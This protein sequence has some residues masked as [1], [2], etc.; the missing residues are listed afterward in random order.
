MRRSP[1][2]A[3]RRRGAQGRGGAWAVPPAGGRPPPPETRRLPRDPQV[4]GDERRQ[5]EGATEDRRREVLQVQ[6]RRA[7]RDILLGGARRGAPGRPPPG[8]P[9]YAPGGRGPGPGAGD[10]RGGRAP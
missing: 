7:P 2:T 3:L 5:G 9:A 8:G 10:G 4:A 6:A 1:P